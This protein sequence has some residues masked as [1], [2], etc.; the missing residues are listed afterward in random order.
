VIVRCKVRQKHC[1]R[2]VTDA[3]TGQDT[4]EQGVHRQKSREEVA[5]CRNTCQVSA[6]YE[7]GTEG[8]KERIVYFLDGL[9]I[10]KQQDDR[11]RKGT[12][13]V[14]NDTEYNQNTCH[15][16]DGVNYGSSHR[17]VVFFVVF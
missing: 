17:K 1:T 4:E 7:K 16:Q 6:E 2:Y 13:M 10:Q 12:P 15:K 8:S 11:N 14:R 9:S 3:L 5:D